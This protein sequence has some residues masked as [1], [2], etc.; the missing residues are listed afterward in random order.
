MEDLTT[1]TYHFADGSKTISSIN[2]NLLVD[3]RG[4]ERSIE[5]LTKIFMDTQHDLGAVSYEL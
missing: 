3:D 4:R 2:R 5:Q 1:I